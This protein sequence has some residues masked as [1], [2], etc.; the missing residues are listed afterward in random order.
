MWDTWARRS[1]V[2][3]VVMSD[4]RTTAAPK[5]YG[6]GRSLQIVALLLFLG[7]GSFFA[8]PC[9]STGG[10]ARGA[11]TMVLLLLA[12]SRLTWNVYKRTF[13]YRDYLVYLA[14]VIVFGLWAEVQ[15][16]G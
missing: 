2:V 4:H 16:H 7:I 8:L 1:S 13:R 11:F 15:Q 5:V 6:G 3:L 9:L 10:A 12:L 14:V